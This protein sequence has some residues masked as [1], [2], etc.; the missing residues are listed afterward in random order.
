MDL[1]TARAPRAQGFM[2]EHKRP[3]LVFMALEAGLVDPF[4]RRR[5]PG[6]HV[7]AVRVVAVGAAHLAFENWVVVGQSELGFFIEMALKASAGIFLG[8]DD[9]THSLAAA[10][11]RV[12]AAGPMAGLA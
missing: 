10:G 4:E 9:A 3:A 6:P 5:G 1:V 2:L 11:F 8:I 7:F 12:Q